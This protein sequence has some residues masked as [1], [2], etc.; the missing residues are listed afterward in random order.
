M[1]KALDNIRK[2]LSKSQKKKL[3][4]ITILL[5]GSIFLEF[6]GIGLLIPIMAI[7]LSPDYLESNVY[8]N[9][10]S[11]FLE[12]NKIISIKYFIIFSTLIF[13]LLKSVYVVL[14]HFKQNNFLANLNSSLSSRLYH[15][16][17]F[18]QYSSLKSKGTAEMYKNIKV[19][20]NATVAYLTALLNFV[21]EALILLAIISLLFIF[22][23]KTTLIISIVIALFSAIFIKA[24]KFRINWLGNE[25]QALD[26]LISKRLLDYLN[27]IND[28]IQYQKQSFFLINISKLFNKKA[29]IDSSYST[30]NVLPK[31]FLELLV[32]IITIGSIIYMMYNNFDPGLIGLTIGIYASASFKIMPSISK[33]MVSGQSLKFYEPALNLYVNEINSSNSKIS[34]SNHKISFNTLSISSLNFKYDHNE[35]VFENANFEVSKTD[36]IGLQGN[37]GS[38]K[39]TLTSILVGF[40][41]DFSAHVFLNGERVNQSL[42]F[43]RSIISYVPQKVFLFNDNIK[44]NITFGEDFDIDF[45]NKILLCVGLIS[46]K[47]N[48]RDILNTNVGESGSNLSG[49]QSQRVVIARA[50]FKNPEILILDESLSGLETKM[51]E[52][53]LT[54]IRNHFDNITIILISHN[55]SYYKLCNKIYEISNKRIKLIKNE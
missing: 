7:V 20:A 30:I 4:I 28:I 12:S 15:K 40:L 16:Y 33:L 23:F 52:E 38:G 9:M 36:F 11:L 26:D 1:K 46:F 43:L 32:I 34:N 22:D 54:N 48:T 37:S 10:L 3:M 51:G 49:G 42:S 21:S 31:I 2:I 53:I 5:V 18:S 27:G 24:F 50:L 39:S 8:Y 19:E 13:Y 14:F 44:N 47:D 17:S 41:V 25:R 29:S 45:M 6:F 35:I 55:L